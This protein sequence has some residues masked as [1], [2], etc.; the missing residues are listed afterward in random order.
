MNSPSGLERRD[1]FRIFSAITP[2]C[3]GSSVGAD[4]PPSQTA[5]VEAW[6]LL[7]SGVNIPPQNIAIFRVSIMRGPTSHSR[8]QKTIC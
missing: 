7:D 3:L 2:S 1:E 8:S 4:E 5:L 6:A